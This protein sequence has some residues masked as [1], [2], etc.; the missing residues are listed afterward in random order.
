M[1]GSDVLT[2][3][4]GPSRGGPR[5]VIVRHAARH[6]I[7]DIRRSL[8]VGLTEQGMEDAER[9]GRSLRGY[10]LRLF[11]SPAVRCRETAEAIRR[12][13]EAAGALVSL[14]SPEPALCAPYLKDD[15]CLAEASRLGKGFIRAWFDGQFPERWICRPSVAADMVLGPVLARLSEPGG[16]GRLDIHVSHDWEISLLREELLGVRHEEAGWPAYLDG[17]TLSW[18]VDEASARWRS[19]ERRFR[20]EGGRRV[21]DEARSFGAP[22]QRDK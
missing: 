2:L 3:L 8:E 18:E 12:G 5:A 17:I 1:D 4:N 20:F 14:V 22:P 19:A 15:A 10:R 16:E 9:F 13:A 21:S 6:P 11:H 7:E